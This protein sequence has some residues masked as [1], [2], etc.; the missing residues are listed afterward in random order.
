M[1]LQFGY[2]IE[3]GVYLVSL[4]S[5]TWRTVAARSQITIRFLKLTRA[6]T[7]LAPLL[8]SF[9]FCSGCHRDRNAQKQRYFQSG[10]DYFQKGRYPEAIIQFR[11]AV[12]MDNRFASEHYQLAQ[13]YLRQAE[14]LQGVCN[15]P[16]TPVLSALQI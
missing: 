9:F 15:A 2:I 5:R 4:I 3:V 7:L 11:N 13:C 14:W 10:M 8:L 16:N 6:T 1:G 12:Q